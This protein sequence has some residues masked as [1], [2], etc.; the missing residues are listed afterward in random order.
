MILTKTLAS[1]GRVIERRIGEV[2]RVGSF[3]GRLGQNTWLKRALGAAAEKTISYF[4][5]DSS[6]SSAT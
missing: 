4:V 2:H 6:L 3:D 5:V 1:L